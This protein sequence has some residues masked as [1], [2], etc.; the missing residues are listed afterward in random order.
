MTPICLVAYTV[1]SCRVILLHHDDPSGKADYPA[2]L[3][4]SGEL[5]FQQLELLSSSFSRASKNF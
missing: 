3:Y 1:L 2:V 4:L 5:T